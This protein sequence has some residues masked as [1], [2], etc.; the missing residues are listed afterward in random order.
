MALLGRPQV[1]SKLLNKQLARVGWRMVEASIPAHDLIISRP[2]RFYFRATRSRS[3]SSASRRAATLRPRAGERRGRAGGAL[4]PW[5]KGALAV[6]GF[7][8]PVPEV[9]A[10]SAP[11]QGQELV[12]PG[13][14]LILRHR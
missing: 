14:S 3:S 4:W 9:P 7:G 2:R 5:S 13:S 11:R 8:V 10:V 12:T 1:A 6:Q